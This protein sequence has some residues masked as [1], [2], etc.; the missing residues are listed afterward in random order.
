MTR[1]FVV[2]AVGAVLLSTTAMAQVAGSATS[3]QAGTSYML[4]TSSG[5]VV[6][7][8][9]A[10][11]RGLPVTDTAQGGKVFVLGEQIGNRELANQPTVYGNAVSGSSSAAVPGTYGSTYGQPAGTPMV[12]PAA[13]AA[14]FVTRAG[15]SGAFEIESSRV[16]LDR[17]S[18]APVRQFANQ[19]IDDHTRVSRNLMA[20]AEAQRLKAPA[21]P[22]MAHQQQVSQLQTLTGSAFD[23]T[24]IQQQVMAHRD[25]V[26]LFESVANSSQADLR[27]FQS[28]AMQTLPTLQHHLREA[29]AMAAGA[30]LASA[31]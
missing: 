2:T 14:D 3:P 19:M 21:M 15:Q 17:A 12:M 20:V 27:P 10:P 9:T 31:R 6:P 8:V 30:P 11:A 5:G 24:Y 25:A 22:D 28:L 7:P 16:A 29:E 26:A 23:R 13:S 4:G 18:A 1:T